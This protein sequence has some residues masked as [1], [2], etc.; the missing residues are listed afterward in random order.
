M[1]IYEYCCQKCNEPFDVFQSITTNGKDIKCPQC[2]SGDVQKKISS[3]SCCSTGGGGNS[4][5]GSAGG[6]GGDS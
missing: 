5:V 2:G 6:L 1:P 3:F 4:P